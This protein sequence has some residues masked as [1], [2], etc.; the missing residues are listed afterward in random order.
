MLL[1]YS[2]SFAMELGFVLWEYFTSLQC[3]REDGHTRNIT[4]LPVPHQIVCFS[5]DPGKSYVL[6]NT[7]SKA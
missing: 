6:M 7:M 3:K 2:C 1:F 5:K 4:D